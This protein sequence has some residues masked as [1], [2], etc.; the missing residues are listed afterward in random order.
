[1]MMTTITIIQNKPTPTVTPI[2]I[3]KS[4]L[5]E[6]DVLLELGVC[7]DWV[8]DECEEDRSKRA[9]EENVV[10]GGGG[11]EVMSRE[12]SKDGS[13]LEREGLFVDEGDDGEADADVEFGG[14]K[15]FGGDVDVDVVGAG[16]RD[17]ASDDGTVSWEEPIC[18]VSGENQFSSTPEN[19][20]PPGNPVIITK[21]S[22]D[23]I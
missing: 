12:E 15:D 1:M 8:F 3:C 23:F 2:N 20:T 10:L 4:E 21:Q 13:C 14:H 5:E 9:L 19:S 7:L 17:G 16:G 18:E 6:E 22:F 11:G